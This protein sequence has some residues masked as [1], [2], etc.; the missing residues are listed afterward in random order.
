MVLFK[1]IGFVA[2]AYLLFYS[3]FWLIHVLFGMVA[4]E[5]QPDFEHNL[6]HEVLILLP[7]YKPGSIFFR[8]LD[9]VAALK[10]MYPIQVFVLL[11]EAEPVFKTYA[12]DLGL[13][14]EERSFLIMVGTPTSMRF[15]TSVR[16]W[17]ANG[18]ENGIPN[19]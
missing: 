2:A 5:R 6:T 11:Q 3:L 4:R 7:A 13:Y 12:Q 17:R 15:D 8:V 19:L 1:I 14:V 9:R 10:E 16:W 18:I